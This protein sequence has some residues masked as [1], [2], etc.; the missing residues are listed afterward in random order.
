MLYVRIESLQRCHI[1]VVLILVEIYFC[2][3]TIRV[4]K[5]YLVVVS[6]PSSGV[7]TDSVLI[8]YI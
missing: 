4:A 6:V 7:V 8:T 1:L 5:P 2:T 3:K